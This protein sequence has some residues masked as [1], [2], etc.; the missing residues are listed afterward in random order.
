MPSETV[1]NVG[2]EPSTSY[3]V[4]ALAPQAIADDTPV[5][6]SAIDRRSYPRKRCLVVFTNKEAGAT[7][8]TMAV[9]V[10]ESATSGGE[11]TACTVSG[12]ATAL[13][14]DG[15]QV[16]S[17]APNKAKPFIKTTLTGSHG[18]VDAICS[19]VVLFV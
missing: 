9:T 11:Y 15:S 12:T 18:D 10:T 8:H 14:A 7:T 19:V 13:S 2:F 1:R 16:V 4:Q 3:I 5:L 17:V 6:S